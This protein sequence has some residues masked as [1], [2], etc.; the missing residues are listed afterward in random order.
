M[1]G[2]ELAIQIATVQFQKIAGCYF[3]T[4]SM[5]EELRESARKSKG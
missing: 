4:P 1:P 2:S 5:R 3:Q